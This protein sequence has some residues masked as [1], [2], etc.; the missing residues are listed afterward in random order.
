MNINIIRLIFSLANTATEYIPGEGAFCP[1]CLQIL[2]VRARARVTGGCNEV[3]YCR[4]DRCSVTFK[5][6]EKDYGICKTQGTVDE[7]PKRRHIRNR[8]R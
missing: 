7:K 3:R 5:A 8:K 6:V 2:G 4:C 1:V